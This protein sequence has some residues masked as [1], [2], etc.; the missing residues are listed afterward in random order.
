MYKLKLYLSWN[1]YHEYNENI[2]LRLVPDDAGVYK[3][4]VQ[5]K[6]G[7]LKPFYVGQT[8]NLKKRLQEHLKTYETNACIKKQVNHYICHFK[9]ALLSRQEERDGAERALYLHYKPECNDPEAI[10]SGPDIDIN[11][12]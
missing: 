3:L 6:N 7:R 8:K 2:V 1:G 4:S 12:D 9:F 10:P 11:P 5:L